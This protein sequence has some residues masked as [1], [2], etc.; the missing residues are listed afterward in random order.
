[1]NKESN[2]PS[3][4]TPPK[5]LLF[6]CLGNICRSPLAEGVFASLATAR[7]A[8]DRF[9]LDSC[10]T[11]AWHVGETPD[12]RSIE[13]AR[14]HGVVLHHRAR[15]LQPERDFETFDLLLAMDRSNLDHILRAGCPPERAAL[16]RS[17]DPGLRGPGSESLEHGLDVPDPYSGG[18]DGFEHVYQMLHAACTGLLGTL[19]KVPGLRE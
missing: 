19:L 3:P 7:G 1:V 12:R 13:V 8:C 15:Q 5:A 11:G 18:A 9:I 14:R 17:Y 16:M 2:H 4:H 10:G 6:V